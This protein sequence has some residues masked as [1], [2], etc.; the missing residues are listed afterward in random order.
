ML[1]GPP[2]SPH[3]SAQLDNSSMSAQLTCVSPCWAHMLPS[4]HCFVGPR[5]QPYVFL[6]HGR[7]TLYPHLRQ[8]RAGTIT[9]ATVAQL[10]NRAGEIFSLHAL[11]VV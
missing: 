11:T 8:N 2:A 1:A 9:A 7:P 10:V 5:C 4:A 3:S 6:Y